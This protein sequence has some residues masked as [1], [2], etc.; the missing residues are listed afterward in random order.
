M[1]KVF[2][3]L[4]TLLALTAAAINA[5]DVPTVVDADTLITVDDTLTNVDDGTYADT[6]RIV[7]STEIDADTLTAA[8][9]TLTVVD[10]DTLITTAD[11]LTDDDVT[12]DTLTI[13]VDTDIDTDIDTDTDTPAAVKPDT[14][15]LAGTYL[16]FG[17]GLS[18]GTIPIFTKWQD[19]LPDSMQRFGITPLFGRDMVPGDTMFLRY[20]IA[21]P[22]DQFNFTLPFAVSV[23]NINAGSATSYALSFFHTSKQFQAEIFPHLDTSNRRVHIHETLRYYSLT[24]EATY[25]KAIPP[26]FFSVDGAQQTFL[27]M[28]IGASPVNVM[29]RSGGVKADL[30]EDDLRMRAVADSARTRLG[31]LSANGMSFSWRIGF[32]TIR[33]YG[34]GGGLELGLYYGGSYTFRFYADG[35]QIMTGSINADDDNADKPLTFLSNR[36]EFKATFL[37]SSN[38]A[39]LVSQ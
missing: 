21:Q 16:G 11:T 24:L 20:R 15:K 32:S 8:D 31:N 3:P 35:E 25:M 36:I 17:V 39:K 14:A 2:L 38:R 9:D 22:P 18:V 33:N 19:A 4:I 37:M 12:T 5:D 10:A 13:A 34:Q 26:E 1:N 30:A 28:S 6:L 23:H 29:T 7:N 27:S